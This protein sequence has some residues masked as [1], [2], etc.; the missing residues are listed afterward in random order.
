MRVL[1]GRLVHCKV[2][3][4][5]EILEDH[6]IGF[7]ETE[8]GKIHFIERATHLNEVAQQYGFD[9]SSVETLTQNQ[10]LLPGLVD[11]HIHAPQYVNS[12]VGYDRQLLDWLDTYTFPTEA[13]FSDVQVAKDIY[14]KVVRRTLEHGT[15]T[16]CYFAT[17]H[18]EASKELCKVV[19]EYGQRAFVGKVNMDQQ[20]PDFYKEDTQQ[21]LEDTRSF[22]EF[23]RG[24]NN[25]LVN[26]I[27]TPRFAPTC[28]QALLEGLGAIAKEMDVHVQ[29]H[30]CEQKPEVKFTLELFPD[31]EHCAAIF[32]RAGLL[33]NKTV[34][35]HCIYLE[36]NELKLFQERK[37]GIA[38][39]PS[40]NFCIRS[41]I[42]DTR[43]M[44]DM[45]MKIGLGTDVSGGYSPSVF[46]A[47]QTSIDASKALGFSKPDDYKTLDHHEAL[48]MATLGGARV[49][50]LDDKI[51]NFEVGKEFDALL[52]DVEAPS[53]THPV[54]DVFH[55]DTF[56]DILMKFLY[57]GDD[58]NILKRFVAGREISVE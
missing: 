14:P 21:S 45:G 11:T 34:M 50:C 25:P 37:V 47:I 24:M 2:P 3:E 18:L 6:L 41:G 16:A 40:S 10:F 7:E 26:P 28:S 49:L 46:S 8:N 23:V 17:I 31:H 33:T 56:D 30:I 44:L 12:G 53:S 36:E 20:S 54:F 27:I 43:R 15:T 9:V 57:L 52:V 39:C 48:Y 4:K 22:V 42:L 5:V 32:E 55:K 58:R 29:S 35:A 13:S 1:R 19:A 38:H 51:G